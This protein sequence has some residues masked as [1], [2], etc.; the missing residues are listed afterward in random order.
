MG[1][2]PGVGKTKPYCPQSPL[3][4]DYLVIDDDINAPFARYSFSLDIAR[5][6]LWRG[7]SGEGMKVCAESDP[8]YCFSSVP[9]SFAVPK[10]FPVVGQQWTSNGRT[11]K[12]IAKQVFALLGVRTEVIVIAGDPS[13]SDTANKLYYFSSERGLIA[14]RSPPVPGETPSLRFSESGYGFGEKNCTITAVPRR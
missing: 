2:V 14:L 12:A 9:L 6:V 11:Y 1:L 4:Y 8:L 13:F 7:H 10:K 3:T 5:R